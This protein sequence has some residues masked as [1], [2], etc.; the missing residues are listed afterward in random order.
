MQ[1]EQF[2][3]VCASDNGNWIA[4]GFTGK[5]Y[6]SV[7]LWDARSGRLV[8]EKPL[9]ARLTAV[10]LSTAT[11][12]LSAEYINLTG[13]FQR[14]VALFDIESGERRATITPRSPTYVS[15]S[16]CFTPTGELLLQTKTQLEWWSPQTGKF[17]RAQRTP[18][19]QAGY[20]LSTRP[21]GRF[22]VA[23]H[24][25]T[26]PNDGINPNETRSGLEVLSERDGTLQSVLLKNA[27]KLLTY[28]THP[29]RE[30]V[31][32]MLDH[33]KY[34]LVQ[35]YQAAPQKLLATYAFLKPVDEI[36]RFSLSGTL[37]YVGSFNTRVWDWS[38]DSVRMPKLREV[39][40]FGTFSLGKREVYNQ[41]WDGAIRD[42]Q[43]DQLIVR[44]HSH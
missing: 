28:T 6:D 17:L 32:A 11:K 7:A 14:H 44:L 40:D 4:G 39:R 19:S 30:L 21:C 20:M 18:Q 10:E 8:F 33:E 26:D 36:L 15:A 9:Y 25:N 22:R 27:T 24:T 37:L 34:R 35:I 16:P 41:Y 43:T 42:A 31:A 13:S 2:P 1:R 5:R 29:T 38:N 23:E 12:T 3:N